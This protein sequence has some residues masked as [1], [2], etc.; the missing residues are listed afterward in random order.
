MSIN[1]PGVSG[2]VLQQVTVTGPDGTQQSISMTVPIVCL[3]DA[4]G[5]VVDLSGLGLLPE[6]LSELQAI[7]ELLTHLT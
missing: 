2:G 3:V 7:R 6:I 1:Q 5:R 4:S